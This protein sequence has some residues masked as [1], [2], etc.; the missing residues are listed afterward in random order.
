MGL[1]GFDLDL[2]SVVPF[3]LDCGPPA[4][5]HPPLNGCFFVALDLSIGII[6][7]TIAEQTKL[8][9]WV[10]VLLSSSTTLELQKDTLGVQPDLRVSSKEVSKATNLLHAYLFCFTQKQPRQR[11]FESHWR[12]CL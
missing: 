4:K 2:A 3:L 5:K 11:L 10:H 6:H 8:G 7:G 9:V 12:G 1:S